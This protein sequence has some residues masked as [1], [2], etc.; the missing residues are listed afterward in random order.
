[1]P[2]YALV[3]ITSCV[4][5]G[6]RCH[7]IVLVVVHWYPGTSP[8]R[9]LIV[10]SFPVTDYKRTRQTYMLSSPMIVCLACLARDWEPKKNTLRAI[11]M[12]IR[13]SPSHRTRKTKTHAASCT[14]P[15]PLS[16]HGSARESRR[17][18]GRIRPS[19]CP[20]TLCR[21]NASPQCLARLVKCV[22]E[23]LSLFP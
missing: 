11:S 5:S 4:Q 10:R 21:S 3:I 22:G 7:T 9:I 19:W 14:V 2:A 16:R 17:W 8:S 23:T 13:S 15:V 20:R 18:D 12:A 6:C 1:M